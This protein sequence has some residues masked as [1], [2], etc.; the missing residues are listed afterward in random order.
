MFRSSI[1]R[2][3]QLF[4][5]EGLT[6]DL[7]L[8]HGTFYSVYRHEKGMER[9]Y[10]KHVFR[11]TTFTSAEI[12]RLRLQETSYQRGFFH[13][14]R[15]TTIIGY[16]TGRFL[17]AYFSDGKRRRGLCKNVPIDDKGRTEGLC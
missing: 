9:A 3:D 17:E 11:A 15:D 6:V 14:S 7:E 1:A 8:T 16:E 4:C 12:K 5:D 10:T 2:V 13:E